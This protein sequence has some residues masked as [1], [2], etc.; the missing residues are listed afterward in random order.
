MIVYQ[1]VKLISQRKSQAVSE[2]KS[3]ECNI[4]N[5]VDRR[6]SH[7]KTLG[8][9]LVGKHNKV[10][11]QF[12]VVNLEPTRIAREALPILLIELPSR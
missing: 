3:G 1:G 6:P 4:L 12:A 7:C 10:R 2:P 11:G 5:M 8:E 9:F